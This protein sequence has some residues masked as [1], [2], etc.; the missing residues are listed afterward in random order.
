MVSQDKKEEATVEDGIYVLRYPYT[1]P[2]GQ[3]LKQVDLRQRLKARDIREINRRTS[4]PDEYEMAGVSVMC[5]IPVEDILDMDAEDYL[6][7]RDR[8]FRRVGIAARL[9]EG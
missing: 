9:Q 3:E 6:A 7:L 8:F 5:G 1:T 4:T 2:A